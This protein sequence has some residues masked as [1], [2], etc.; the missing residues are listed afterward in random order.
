MSYCLNWINSYIEFYDTE[1]TLTYT[2]SCFSV[3]SI[4]ITLSS[5]L[6]HTLASNQST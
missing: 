4:T 1:C 6:F 2:E 3:T 5:V